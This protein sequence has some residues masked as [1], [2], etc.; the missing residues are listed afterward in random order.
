MDWFA[1]LAT[2]TPPKSASWFDMC[3]ACGQ[4]P[5]IVAQNGMKR[6]YC[7]R[8]CALSDCSQ[9]A[10][11]REV[12]PDDVTFADIQT[13][14]SAGWK[15][16]QPVLERVYKVEYPHIVIAAYLAHISKLTGSS[17]G[18]QTIQTYFASECVCGMAISGPSL[19][20]DSSCGICQPVTSSFRTFA[21]GET[22]K[23]G[24]KGP[25][26]YTYQEPRR[27]HRYAT[28]ASP[29][30]YRVMVVCD[31]ALPADHR[32]SRSRSIF[33]HKADGVMPR[34]IL[35]YRTE[36]RETSPETAS[37]A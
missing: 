34:Y 9:A 37:D 4:N 13:K 7:S 30:P 28:C 12:E 2:Q 20:Q 10:H 35:V 16:E 31:V 36:S 17:H 18:C 11:L 32:L 33:S 23:V 14:F 19:C 26:I 5:K 25:G 21:C 3:E 27:A 29:S 1:H 8:S 24:R 15:K 22:K 6:P